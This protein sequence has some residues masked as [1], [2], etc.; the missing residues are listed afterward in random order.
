M[1]F[2]VGMTQRIVLVERLALSPVRQVVSFLVHY[3]SGRPFAIES[4]IANSLNFRT[5]LWERC[6]TSLFENSINSYAK[7]KRCLS[8]HLVI[9]NIRSFRRRISRIVPSCCRDGT[10]EPHV[11]ETSVN[12]IFIRTVHVMY[13]DMS[14]EIAAIIHHALKIFIYILI[15]KS[16]TL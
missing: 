11:D 8:W 15:H 12:L 1:Y 13:D 5:G 3:R 4:R 10:R 9:F 16:L 6:W 2:L 7:T 14:C